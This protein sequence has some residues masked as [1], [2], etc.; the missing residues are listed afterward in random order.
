LQRGYVRIDRTWHSGDRVEIAL[1]LA[2]QRL[3]AHPNVRQNRD[4]VAL[5]R[6]PLVYCL[7]RID[8]PA[9]LNRISLSRDAA[10]QVEF[11]DELL[12]GVVTLQASAA[13]EDTED[14]PRT[15]YRS[16]PPRTSPASIKAVPYYA[17]DNREPGEM[18][19]WL[20]EA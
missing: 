11:E 18:L 13:S 8:N 2:V 9:P 7:E 15:L 5:R 19:V 16:E 17:W 14:W 6:G 10:F 20:R 12:G 4:R 3:Y 1:D